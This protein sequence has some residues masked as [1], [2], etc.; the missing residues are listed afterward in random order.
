MT[1]LGLSIASYPEI[2]IINNIYHRLGK[3]TRQIGIVG[4]FQSRKIKEKQALTNK[5]SMDIEQT[6]RRPRMEWRLQ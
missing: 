2:E 5:G 3:P 4:T 1:P 6:W